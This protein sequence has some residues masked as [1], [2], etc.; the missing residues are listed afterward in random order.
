MSRK[1][2]NCPDVSLAAAQ[3]A[4]QQRTTASKRRDRDRS[5]RTPPLRRRQASN[6]RRESDML[7]PR[8]RL[9]QVSTSG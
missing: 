3:S 6:W 7:S 1:V 4:A 8:R 5:F 9:P 2:D